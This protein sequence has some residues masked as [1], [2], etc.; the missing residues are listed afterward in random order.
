METK[1]TLRLEEKLIRKAKKHAKTR[2]KSV[3]KMVADYFALLDTEMTASKTSAPITES[4]WGRLEG[5]GVD[6]ED[7]KKHLEE[8]YL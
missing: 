6:E 8:K 3:S 7:Y 4:L 5:K 2:G 1:L